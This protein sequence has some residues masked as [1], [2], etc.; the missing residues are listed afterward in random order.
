MVLTGGM[1]Q[2]DN[3]LIINKI[4]Y[5]MKNIF[6]SV[7]VLSLVTIGFSS[8]SAQVSSNGVVVNNTVG[9]N[10]FFDASTNF[11]TASTGTPNNVGKGLYFPT[12]NLTTWTFKT[13]NMDGI[14]YPTAFD[15]MV[16]YN[17]ASG[18]TVSGQGVQVAV[19]PGFYYFSNPGQSTSITNGRWLPMGGAPVS[20]KVTIGTA[21]TTTNTLINVSN[22]VDKQ[23]YAIKGSFTTTGTSTAVTIPSPPG[24][25]SL[26]GITIYKVNG[27][28]NKVVYSR[29]L[30]SYNIGTT[31][32]AVTGSP[33]MS[34]VYPLDTYDYVLEYIK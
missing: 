8:L 4:Q 11:D 22:G 18:N 24:M 26:Y 23:V 31:N 17:S 5:I 6:R 10:P 27:T 25:T 19:T 21:E 2:V 28:G 33:S 12:T 29:D 3:K 30:Y 32:N 15:G 34:V 13:A 16:V 7:V 1:L 9:E 20:P 14:T